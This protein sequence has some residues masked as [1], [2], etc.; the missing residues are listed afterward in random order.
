M[1]DHQEAWAQEASEEEAHDQ[2][3]RRRLA[4]VANA[5]A[6]LH[7]SASIVELTTISREAREQ[8][9]DH[10]RMMALMGT[11]GHRQRA[12][13][14]I[15]DKMTY[16]ELVEFAECLFGEQPSLDAA[17]FPSHLARWARRA[18]QL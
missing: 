11:A 7:E 1:T 8:V 9:D 15:V 16:L 5:I 4:A 6:P 10:R 3:R 18:K 12:V 2:D 13:A 14:C 17:S